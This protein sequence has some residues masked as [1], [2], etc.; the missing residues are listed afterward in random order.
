[1]EENFRR[2][3]KTLMQEKVLE[4]NYK[5]LEEMG[6]DGN[7]GKLEKVEEELSK[8]RK[9]V[10]IMEQRHLKLTN[11]LKEAQGKNVTALTMKKEL[12]ALLEGER[13]KQQQLCTVVEVLEKSLEEEKSKVKASHENNQFKKLYEDSQAKLKMEQEKHKKLSQD[14][15]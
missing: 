15:Q 12:E 4:E 10:A 2:Q 1:M 6:N 13:S 9:Q 7:D 14:S 8:S 3:I 11:D 5:V